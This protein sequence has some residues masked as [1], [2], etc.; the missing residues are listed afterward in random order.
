MSFELA[1]PDDQ[2]RQRF[3]ALK[4]PG[5]VASLLDVRYPVLEYWLFIAHPDKK[6]I[7]FTLS[8]ASSGFRTISAPTPNLKIIQQKLNQVLSTVYEV[9]KPAHGFVKTKSIVTNAQVHAGQTF[10]FNLDLQDFF[11]AINFGRVRGMFMA[12]PY[13]LPDSV[14]TVLAQIC[15]HKNELPQGAPTSP[16][17]S[18]MI[19]GQLDDQLFSLAKREK[20]LYTRYADDI[21]FSTS[22]VIFPQKIAW[23]KY[24]SLTEKTTWRPGS[25]VRR[26]IKSNGFSINPEKSRMQ[27]INQHQEVTGLTVNEFPN[28]KRRY[29]R[30]IRAMLHAW[31]KYGL[32]RVERE[33]YD[34]YNQQQRGPYK[35]KPSFKQIVKGKI[36]FLGMV[37][38]Q[39]NPIYVRYRDW[40][41]RLTTFP[42]P[43]SQVPQAAQTIESDQSFVFEQWLDRLDNV[44]FPLASILWT[45]RANDNPKEKYEHLLHFFEALAQFMATILWSGFHEDEKAQSK[46]K[47]LLAKEQVKL[48]Q[49]SF[50]TWRSIFEN[51]SAYMR[52]QLKNSEGRA[53]CCRLFKTDKMEILNLLCTQ[54]LL[55]VFHDTNSMRNQKAHGGLVS[56]AEAEVQLRELEKYLRTVIEIFRDIW[57]A[58]ELISSLG[59][60]YHSHSGLYKL[61]IQ[62]VMSDRADFAKQNR[63]FDHP[64]D[65]EFLYL[66][67]PNQQ[68]ALKLLPFIKILQS[69]ITE[70]NACYFYSRQEST[71]HIR[72]VSYHF[73]PE[74]EII[75]E[76]QDTAAVLE[77]FL[78]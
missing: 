2:L 44:P 78:Q 60:T 15:C 68:Q 33:Y 59:G 19:C 67:D 63:T 50:G 52:K 18:N 17:I 77:S 48:R 71:G 75:R 46:L 25:E 72:F 69:P 35:S 30:Q 65:N 58:Y 51:L 56:Q 54:K 14:A 41:R 13:N 22:R 3:F 9:K 1:L 7:T 6:Y 5:D 43:V 73:K 39:N 24:N 23:S 74:P 32:A 45:Y 66:S 70:S 4:T 29:V 76:F 34:R 27:I 26:I 57:T 64:L 31:E 36:E 8:K 55:P 20:C 38:G 10:V 47:A 12:Q 40:F 16:V 53:D 11:P 62:R 42:D 61:R 49:S 37:R 28:V 21:T